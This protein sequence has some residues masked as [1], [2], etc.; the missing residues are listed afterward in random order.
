DQAARRNA[1]ARARAVAAAG[2]LPP[3]RRPAR[4]G[5]RGVA[6][7]PSLLRVPRQELVLPRGLRPPAPPPRG[8][9]D[10][11][12]PRA[13]VPDTRGHDDLDLHPFPSRKPG[14]ARQLLRARARGV[15][16]PHLLLAEGRRGLRLL[17]QRLGGL[18]AAQ[19]PLARGTDGLARLGSLRVRRV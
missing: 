14:P 7:W 9:R 5:A 1:Q 13:S 16:A 3:R 4:R 2:E 11:R 6:E 15:A 18:R 12:R 19:R 10:R 8:A 17:Q